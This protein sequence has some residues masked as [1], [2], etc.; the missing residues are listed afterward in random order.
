MRYFHIPAL[1]VFHWLMY[2]YLTWYGFCITRSVLEKYFA[3]I[4]IL[5]VQCRLACM[6]PFF[7]HLQEELLFLVIFKAKIILL[8]SSCFQ[9]NWYLLMLIC[10]SWYM[11]RSNWTTTRASSH[12]SIKVSFSIVLIDCWIVMQSSLLQRWWK[13][14]IFIHLGIIYVYHTSNY[15]LCFRPCLGLNHHLLTGMGEWGEVFSRCNVQTYLGGTFGCYYAMMMVVSM[16]SGHNN[17]SP[18]A[19]HGHTC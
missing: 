15:R 10:I 12:W 4:G 11:Q 1:R 18:V 5:S 17:F 7:V 3:R 6:L 8:F 13:H 14:P 9:E 2:F 16:D 19:T